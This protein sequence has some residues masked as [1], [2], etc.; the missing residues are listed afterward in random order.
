MSEINA[1]YDMLQKGGSQSGYGSSAYG[2][3]GSSYSSGYG[4][5]TGYGA[6]GYGGWSGYS[7]Y[8]R[9]YGGS[10]GRNTER[11]EYQAAVNYIR[12][13]MY[14]EAINA[15]SGVPAS[16]R[17]AKWYYLSAAANARQGN[18][19]TALEHAKKACSLEPDNEEYQDLL[20]RLRNGGEF[21]DN[22]A[23]RYSSGLDLDKICLTTCALNM[24]LGGSGFPCIC[25][26]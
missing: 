4:A 3:P 18:K 23:V 19:V 26:C 11:S 22:Y 2:A 14:K 5:G 12:N 15:L 7:D 16:E 25:F 8:D 21:Y 9:R 1:A 24:C 17:D 13:G 20:T 6:W 10:A